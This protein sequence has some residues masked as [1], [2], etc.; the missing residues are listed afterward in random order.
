[1]KSRPRFPDA[2]RSARLFFRRRST[3]PRR[4]AVK[5]DANVKTDAAR[6]RA[7]AFSTFYR[8]E[9]PPFS[10]KAEKSACKLRAIR[11]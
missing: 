10:Q 4:F 2:S 7:F 6:R 8:Q 5:V 1:M 9:K 11:S 3:F